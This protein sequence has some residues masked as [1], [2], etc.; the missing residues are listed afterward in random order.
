MKKENKIYIFSVLT[1]IVAAG[2]FAYTYFI[3]KVP[4]VA[5]AQAANELDG[6]AWSSNIGWISFNCLTG[7]AGQT[8]ICAT[9]N[10]K[11]EINN[12][13]F[14]G[15]AWVN[16]EDGSA[17]TTNIGWLSFNRADTGNP[18]S[19]DPG[20]G[21]GAI[22]IL[23]TSN[24]VKGWARFITATSTSDGWDGWVR[25]DNGPTS[26][27]TFNSA[28]KEFEGYAWGGGDAGNDAGVA[29]W[30]SM[31]CNTGSA[32]SSDV[33]A[34]SNYKVTWAGG[35]PTGSSSN[36][37]ANFNATNQGG[38]TGI[39]GSQIHFTWSS[40][41]Q[42]SYQLQ[43]DDSPADWV[44]SDL[45]TGCITS[46]AQER[47]ETIGGVNPLQFDTSTYDWRLQVWGSSDCTTGGSGWEVATSTF[48]TSPHAYPTVNFS[49]TPLEPSAE[50]TVSFT[51]ETSFG[52]APQNQS[53]SWQFDPD[54]NPLTSS[55]QNATTT[56]ASEG[57][58]TATLTATDEELAAGGGTPGQWGNGQCDK[59]D[60][61]KAALPLPEFKEVPPVGFWQ[62]LK[63]LFAG[64]WRV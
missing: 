21:T 30:I 57:T 7:G 51:D 6:Y 63:K 39:C 61:L 22:A 11:V 37:N 53:W 13:D 35:A 60:T 24:E 8:D 49:W 34:T 40:V 45:D 9:S 64:V 10:Y 23:N 48:T 17:S 55:D 58:K 28:S 36:L 43:A 54:G 1:L 38:G 56:F 19:A 16:P 14:S 59:Q 62:I 4:E 27:V 41:N 25:F 18:P 15:Y 29:G 46:T 44:G 2:I 31:N 5:R 50:E 42:G 33:C 32:T 52:S 26:T 3:Y 12:G 47:F 20:G